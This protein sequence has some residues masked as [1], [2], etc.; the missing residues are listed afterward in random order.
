MKQVHKFFYEVEATN[1]PFG[2]NCLPVKVEF[3]LPG[4][5]ELSEIIEQ[6]EFYL[7]ACGFYL[8]DGH[9]LDFVENDNLK[10]TQT[11]REIKVI[12]DAVAKPKNSTKSVE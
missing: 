7:K 6:F 1:E 8:P 3:T 9:H 10:D 12:L 11:S 5:I 4:D 2:H